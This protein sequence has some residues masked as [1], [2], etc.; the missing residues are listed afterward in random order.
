[1]VKMSDAMSDN[2]EVFN[3]AKMDVRLPESI[4]SLIPALMRSRGFR[5][6]SEYIRDLIQRDY[7]GAIPNRN[8]TVLE[9]AFKELF[10]NSLDDSTKHQEISKNE[11]LQ[12]LL[13]L[14]HINL[15]ILSK[16]SSPQLSKDQIQKIVN[17]FVT[18]AKA[19][20]PIKE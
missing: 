11:I 6:R 5:T 12:R 3:M 8:K 13:I 19:K 10:K 4:T 16:T 17:V 9:D 14:T 2:K 15:E 7:D 1:M 20:Y 18:D